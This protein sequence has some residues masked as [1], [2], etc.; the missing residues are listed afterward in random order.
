MRRPKT[1]SE[2]TDTWFSEVIDYGRPA[3]SLME[4][5]DEILA[6][7]PNRKNLERLYNEVLDRAGMFSSADKHAKAILNKEFRKEFR[8]QFSTMH[9][10]K[11]QCSATSEFFSLLRQAL[12]YNP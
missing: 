7:V 11:G 2:Y 3:T 12:H 8:F 1:F 9:R 6:L 10:T 4:K 5:A